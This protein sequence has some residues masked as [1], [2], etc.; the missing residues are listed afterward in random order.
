[1]GVED[2]RQEDEAVSAAT[3][4]G[5]QGTTR[6]RMRGACTIAIPEGLPNASVPSSSTAKLND[7]F[8]GRGKG[9]TGRVRW[10][11]DRQQFAVEIVF[12]PFFLR[13]RPVAA[14]VKWMLSR[15][16]SGWGRC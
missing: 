10:G 16:N 3:Q 2:G 8:S 9:G 4:F 12:D 7:L 13:A 11:Q 5:R 6:G 15:A 14:A 1:M